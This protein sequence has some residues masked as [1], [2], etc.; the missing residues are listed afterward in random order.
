M[1][2]IGIPRALLYYYFYPLWREFFTG[3]GM[4]VV[5]SPETNKRIMDAGVKVTLSEVCLPVKIFF[6]HVLALADEVDY[7]FVPRIIKVEP[8]AY[9]CPKF[10]GLPDMLRARIPDLPPFLEP[11]VDMRKEETDPFRCWENCFRE[12]GRVITRDKRLVDEATRRAFWAQQNFQRRLAAGLL[13]PQALEEGN[14]GEVEVAAVSEQCPLRIGLLGHPYNLYDRYISMNLIGKLRNLGVSPVTPESLPAQDIEDKI[15]NLPKRLFWTLG[16]RM[17]GAALN[18]FADTRLDGLIYLSSFGC[19]PESLVEELVARWAKQ[20][21][22]L[23]LMLL[24][25]DEHTGEA[26][27]N[28]RLEAF[29]EMIKRRRKK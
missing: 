25:I 14:T 15:E 29:T 12:V 9:I 27:T 5:V 18:F 19:G 22:G 16:K 2:R 23:P 11:A 3:L 1:K 24:T 21:G 28:T 20:Q 6:G 7:L 10:M 4:Q 26:G 17:V 8:R 13:L